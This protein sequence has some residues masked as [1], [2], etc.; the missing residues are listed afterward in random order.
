MA[1]REHYKASYL[2]EVST[3]SDTVWQE[4]VGLS[5]SPAAGADYI[6]FWSVELIN[7]THFA[8]DAKCR[9]RTGSEVSVEF[10]QECRGTNEYPSYSGF[11]RLTG[12]GSPALVTLEIQSEWP[13]ST[14]FAQNANLVAIRLG[15]GD[16]YTEVLGRAAVIGGTNTW[17]DV[18]TITWT[19]DAGDYLIFGHSLTDNYTA[20]APVYARL[21]FDG[22]GN[23]EAT[24]G[25]PEVVGPPKNL[26]PTHQLWKR[27]VAPGGVSRTATWQGRS[28]SAGS[29]VGFAANRLLILRLSDFDAAY[30]GELTTL[31]TVAGEGVGSLVSIEGTVTGSPH[32]VLGSWGA[33]G[34]SASSLLDTRLFDSGEQI[35]RS[36]QKS[37]A[38]ASNRGLTSGHNS[39]GQYSAGPRIWSLDLVGD[40]ALTSYGRP[41]SAL[42]VLDLG[43][44]GDVLSAG[45]VGFSEVRVTAALRGARRLITTAGGL[46]LAGLNSGLALGYRTHAS[47]E[48]FH[49][50]A[51]IA[52]MGVARR[53]V[54]TSKAV[55]LIGQAA[56]LMR[57][58]AAV[59]YPLTAA[60]IGFAKLASAARLI[61][62]RRLGISAEAVVLAGLDGRPKYGRFVT[63]GTATV[64]FSGVELAWPRTYVV[65][66][67]PDLMWCAAAPCLLRYSG[68]QFW[69]V[70]PPLGEAWAQAAVTPEA[71]TP[72]LITAEDWS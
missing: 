19:P 65:H 11:Y 44:Q 59:R 69:S 20:T 12:G 10:S 66:A 1:A 29:E 36:F 27:T 8:Y 47:T 5:F 55:S 2:P 58:W 72:A 68:Q 25:H 67:G 56:G 41:G 40:G 32:L 13:G 37:M 48:P 18:A 6:V 14:I 64:A 52:R 9:V 21:A 26:T 50:G 70:A 60:S 43:S 24:S 23:Y 71:W 30:Y 63:A 39:V 42:A 45:S 3:T 15:T 62:N 57:S 16:Q 22:T 28:H 38:A 54:G 4:V 46:F 31:L 33:A 51:Q 61:V 7:K 49:L 53:L 17:S 35:G 34:S